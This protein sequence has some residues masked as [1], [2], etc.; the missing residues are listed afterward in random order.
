M[1]TLRPLCRSLPI[2]VQLRRHVQRPTRIRKQTLP[3]SVPEQLVEPEAV[4]ANDNEAANTVSLEDKLNRL[5]RGKK[6]IVLFVGNAIRGDDGAP[7]LLFRKLEGKVVR[8]RLLDCGTSPQDCINQVVE[9]EPS[10]VIFVNAIDWSLKSGS[11]VLEKLRWT[12]SAAAGSS[13]LGHKVPLSW[14]A[15]LLKI[16]GRER[17]LVIETF[18]IGIQINST[19]GI[20]TP[21]VRKSVNKLLK[22]FKELDP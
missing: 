19:N 6:T 2:L 10:I 17:N 14:V 21:P 5:V 15:S 12:S 1:Y 20:I 13:L 22:A 9:L 4:Q 8:L 3:E 7:H 18:L 11:I 16:M